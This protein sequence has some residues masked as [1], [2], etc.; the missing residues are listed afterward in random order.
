MAV[1]TLPILI[2]ID[3]D[4][5]LAALAEQLAGEPILAIDTESNS[6]YA[7]REQV[8]LIQVSTRSADYI[9]DPLADEVDVHRLGPLLANPAIEKV[10]HAAEY[11]LMCLKRDYQFTIT[12]LFDTM[13]AARVCGH[14]NIGLGTLLAE[15]AG[16]SLDKSHQRDDWGKRPLPADALRYARMDTHY[17][18]QLR[19]YFA[20]KLVALGRWEE[21][22][23]SFDDMATV[24]AA[25]RASFDPEGFW[26]I[27]TPNQIVRREAAILRE[28]YIYREEQARQRDVPPF[29]I[30]IDKALVGLA[31]AAPTTLAD[32][33]KVDGV[34]PGHVRRYGQ[35]LLAAIRRGQAARMPVVPAREPP[36]DPV[37][38]DRYSAL[39]EWRKARAQARGVESDVIVSRE[40][41]WALAQRLPATPDELRAITSLGAWRASQYGD[42]ILEV[43]DRFRLP[44][45]NGNGKGEDRA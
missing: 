10:F 39:R 27:A 38:V 4:R 5:D 43:L 34:G 21:A 32:L 1:T 36:T 14:K 24:A 22:R 40:A 35:G 17:L 6:L 3:S 16:V 28:L 44:H 15:V 2:Y 23:E 13:V 45:T 26:R 29:K 7:Y 20:E 12:N 19:D 37:I 31:Q 41:L 42:E 9:I 11:D 33:E 18:P 8:C 25:Q 30:M